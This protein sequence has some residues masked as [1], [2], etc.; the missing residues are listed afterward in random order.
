[1]NKSTKTM[2]ALGSALLFTIST[3]SYSEE[4]GVSGRAT[5]V[6]EADHKRNK[7]EEGENIANRMGVKADRQKQS[8]EE[9][10]DKVRNAMDY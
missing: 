1:M 10:T 2:L 4:S 8:T 5:A 9:K 7:V 3:N 6:D